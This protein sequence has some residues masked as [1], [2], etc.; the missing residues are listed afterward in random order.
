MIV[1]PLPCEIKGMVVLFLGVVIPVFSLCTKMV[2]I[3]CDPKKGIDWF[4]IC[5]MIVLVI[6]VLVSVFA[7]PLFDM[8]LI[9]VVVGCP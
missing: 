7:T 6:I 4:F 8:Q 9:S 1:I 5:E 2:Y 3:G